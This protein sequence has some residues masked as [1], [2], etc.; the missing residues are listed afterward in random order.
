MRSG[1]LFNRSI[2]QRPPG[3]GGQP[4]IVRREFGARSFG[5]AFWVASRG[6]QLVTAL[7]PGFYGVLHGMYGG[8]RVLLLLAAAGL[9]AAATVLSG[10]GTRGPPCILSRVAPRAK[11]RKIF[12]TRLLVFQRYRRHA[13]RGSKLA[14]SVDRFRVCLNQRGV[15]RQP[16]YF[17]TRIARI[18]GTDFTRVWFIMLSTTRSSFHVPPLSVY[19]VP[20]IR[21]IRVKVLLFRLS[22]ARFA[23]PSIRR[24]L[25]G[26]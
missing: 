2:N 19:S 15:R 8:Y 9:L 10:R 3:P 5:G 20:L 14:G 12:V 16:G 17:I 25:S 22:G 1:W 23:F 6:I 11:H 4:I 18:K 24:D 26:K 13:F 7:G 21:A